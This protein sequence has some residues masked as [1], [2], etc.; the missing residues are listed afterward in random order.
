MINRQAALCCLILFSLVS[1]IS[2]KK[3]ETGSSNIARDG[4]CPEGDTYYDGA[5]SANNLREFLALRLETCYARVGYDQVWDALKTTD[6]DREN[7]GQVR[8]LYSGLS[9]PNENDESTY[10]REHPDLVH[11]NPNGYAP[12][13][14][15]REHVWAKSRGFP[16][17]GFFAYTDLHHIR[18]ANKLVNQDR[19][20]YEYSDDP[21]L[22]AYQNPDLC[23]TC[24]YDDKQQLFYPG[25]LDKGDIARM[26]LYMDVRYDGAGDAV[27][28]NSATPDLTVVKELQYEDHRRGAAGT[29][30]FDEFEPKFG[31]LCTLIKWHS[32]DPVDE[33][34]KERNEA[35]FQ[36]QKNRN[37]FIDHPEYVDMIWNGEC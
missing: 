14:W 33:N 1:T 11:D 12:L 22:P 2:C 25:D 9:S 26:L 5:E 19:N 29:D 34:E 21:S 8:L 4:S 35:I 20:H 13:V 36:I 23:Q 7:Q 10:V 15:N 28:P 18:A 37:P 17:P 27:D 30:G 16:K 6:A 24:R 32:E 31:N 3:R